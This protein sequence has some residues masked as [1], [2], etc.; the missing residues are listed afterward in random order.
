M[1][2]KCARVMPGWFGKAC[3]CAVEWRLMKCA[4]RRHAGF[5]LG[6]DGIKFQVDLCRRGKGTVRQDQ[7]QAWAHT[8]HSGSTTTCHVSR[9]FYH[10]NRGWRC[11]CK[12][13]VTA[14]QGHAPSSVSEVQS[15]QMFVSASGSIV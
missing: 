3:T 15:V 11:S 4:R 6:Q 7:I 2:D 8:G 14:T 12:R 5:S 10:S 1:G 13:G 9:R